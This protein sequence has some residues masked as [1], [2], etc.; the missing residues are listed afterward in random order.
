M[1]IEYVDFPINE[2]FTYYAAYGCLATLAFRGITL[3][4][5]VPKNKNA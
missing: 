4:L 2:P 5:I 3:N 1:A